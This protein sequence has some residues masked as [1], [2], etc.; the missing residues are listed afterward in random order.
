MPS[1]RVAGNASPT[2]SVA[3]TIRKTSGSAT[4]AAPFMRSVVAKTSIRADRL[5][6]SVDDRLSVPWTRPS[7]T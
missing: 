6:G 1:M 5:S 2:A 7:T 4:R 3:G